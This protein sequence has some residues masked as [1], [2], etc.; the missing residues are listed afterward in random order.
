MLNKKLIIAFEGCDMTGKTTQAKILH[1]SLTEAGVSAL[2]IKTPFNDHVTHKIIYHMLFSG[3][4]VRHPLLFQ[5]LQLL[6]KLICQ[7]RLLFAKE[8]III[9]DRWHL[10]SVVYGAAS[11]LSISLIKTLGSVLRE[12]DISVVLTRSSDERL[13]RSAQDSYEADV[14]LQDRVKR[15]YTQFCD[16][17]SVIAVSADRTIADV[18]DN[19]RSV[20]NDHIMM[21]LSTL[22]KKEVNP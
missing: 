3:A 15:L 17:K 9:F 10:S 18:S 1:R 13:S 21:Y 4:A 16:N 22:T 8:D 2:A 6:N 7:T 14:T 5:L 11:G 19:I 12:P 20:L